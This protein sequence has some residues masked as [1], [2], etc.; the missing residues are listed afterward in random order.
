MKICKRT[1]PLNLYIYHKS[2]QIIINLLNTFLLFPENFPFPFYIKPII[3]NEN[4][5]ITPDLNIVA[6]INS[7]VTK[8]KYTTYF[9]EEVNPVSLS[10]LFNSKNGK[11]I[12]TGDIGIKE[13]LYHFDFDGVKYLITEATHIELIEIINLIKLNPNI[14]LVISHYSINKIKEIFDNIMINTFINQ[15]RLIIAKDSYNLHN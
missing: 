12:Y 14:K 8:K 13:D 9:G 7:H 1:K 10:L 3:E 11:I 4:L 15:N 5:E 2:H 6:K